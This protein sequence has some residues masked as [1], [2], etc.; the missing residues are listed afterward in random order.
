MVANIRTFGY[1][2]NI[3]TITIYISPDLVLRVLYVRCCLEILGKAGSHLSAGIGKIA[4]IYR[5]TW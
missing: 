3:Q 4:I 1:Y 5:G 2:R